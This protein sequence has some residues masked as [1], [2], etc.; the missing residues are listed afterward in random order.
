MTSHTK[1]L[2][3][4]DVC[5]MLCLQTCVGLS[6]GQGG[7]AGP[8]SLGGLPTSLGL[9]PGGFGHS[10]LPFPWHS[11]SIKQTVSSQAQI[12]QPR[13]LNDYRRT[14]TR[15]GGR[16][17]RDVGSRPLSRDLVSDLTGV[18]GRR[19]KRVRRQAPNPG[20]NIRNTPSVERQIVETMIATVGATAPPS[21]DFNR[22]AQRALS[23]IDPNISVPDVHYHAILEQN[24]FPHAQVDTSKAKHS[25]GILQSSHSRSEV[26]AQPRSSQP[27]NQPFSSASVL[28]KTPGQKH[29]RRSNDNTFMRTKFHVAANQGPALFGK[30][31]RRNNVQDKNIRND[32]RLIHSVARQPTHT[33]QNLRLPPSS[34]IQGST[35]TL[36]NRDVSA[37]PSPRNELLLPDT[38]K[39]NFQDPKVTFVQTAHRQTSGPL[40]HQRQTHLS[41]PQMEAQ[42]LNPKDQTHH[43]EPNPHLNKM[44][45]SQPNAQFPGPQETFHASAQINN[46]LS[47]TPLDHQKHM[48]D[49]FLA[50]KISNGI[51]VSENL[52]NPQPMTNQGFTDMQSNQMMSGQ[53]Q[54]VNTPQH[55]NNNLGHNPSI[56]DTTNQQ[57]NLHVSPHSQVFQKSPQVPPVRSDIQPLTSD[58]FPQHQNRHSNQH[59]P[60]AFQNQKSNS[61]QHTSGVFPHQNSNSN[62]HVSS[63]FPQNQNGNSNPQAPSV[64][65]QYQK[66]NL[67]QHTP[68]VFPHQNSNSNQ[69]TPGV[70]Q[71][72]QD[73][74]FNEQPHTTDFF[75]QKAHS[76]QQPQPN[77]DISKHQNEL[78]PVNNVLPVLQQNNNGPNQNKIYHQQPD[79]QFGKQPFTTSKNVRQHHNNGGI[80]LGPQHEFQAAHQQNMDPQS[81]H[82]IRVPNLQTQT[83]HTHKRTNH[84]QFPPHQNPSFHFKEKHQSIRNPESNKLFP[85]QVNNERTGVHKSN[86][87]NQLPLPHIAERQINNPKYNKH[88]SVPVERNYP[89]TQR[90]GTFVEQHNSH[91]S[92]HTNPVFPR[93]N[94]LDLIN[95]Q[96]SKNSHQTPT[97][98]VNGQTRKQGNPETSQSNQQSSQFNE[99][100]NHFG[101]QDHQQNPSSNWQDKFPSPNRPYNPSGQS[102]INTHEVKHHSVHSRKDVPRQQTPLQQIHNEKQPHNNNFHHLE[103][104]KEQGQRSRTETQSRAS[105]FK[106]PGAVLDQIYSLSLDL[107]SAVSSPNVSTQAVNNQTNRRANLNTQ[108]NNPSHTQNPPT[109]AIKTQ[110]ASMFHKLQAVMENLKIIPAN[111]IDKKSF[112]KTHVPTTPSTRGHSQWK[113]TSQRRETLKSLTPLERTKQEALSKMHASLHALGIPVSFDSNHLHDAAPLHTTPSPLYTPFQSKSTVNHTLQQKS[114]PVQAQ[115]E[116][117]LNKVASP[118][119]NARTMPPS[120]RG[121][122]PRTTSSPF[123]P[124]SLWKPAPNALSGQPMHNANARESPQ[125]RPHSNKPHVGEVGPGVLT[126]DQVIQQQHQYRPEESYV[127]QE[128]HNGNMGWLNARGSGRRFAGTMEMNDF[129]ANHLPKTF[130]QEF[131][132]A[133]NPSTPSPPVTSLNSLP[134][135]TQGVWSKNK[136]HPPHSKNWNKLDKNG[137]DFKQMTKNRIQSQ[138]RASTPTTTQS[139]VQVSTLSDLQM[140]NYMNSNFN[141]QKFI[142]FFQKRLDAQN[143]TTV[144]EKK[145]KTTNITKTIRKI[146]KPARPANSSTAHAPTTPISSFS[147]SGLP[148][149]PHFDILP[150]R[151]MSFDMPTQLSPTELPPFSSNSNMNI[152]QATEIIKLLEALQTLKNAL[153]HSNSGGGSNF[154]NIYNKKDQTPTVKIVL[155]V[156]DFDNRY[157][158]V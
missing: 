23:I 40:N 118:I 44:L 18:I 90:Q 4:V 154:G 52:K 48:S 126:R 103:S 8:L 11:G 38:H 30:H 2:F 141:L 100:R 156:S 138:P 143:S 136:Q 73:G 79:N 123:R 120:A 88:N 59:T 92:Q 148:V 124:V 27:S 113:S 26:I 62:Q 34:N 78:S 144:D 31:N 102:P 146:E 153:G 16:Q 49:A 84:E 72:H 111:T 10:M 115:K 109:R 37:Q 147:N 66:S 87:N 47:G 21:A 15:S 42:S 13:A 61:N 158:G 5:M 43:L 119:I 131:L 70:F 83:D 85:S 7:I 152:T 135:T 33:Q 108:M 116:R 149:S 32:R 125:I 64:F 157:K 75:S 121:L 60:S 29:K 35:F 122:P 98:S 132:Q 104:Q 25:A 41:D 155:H 105:N 45:T 57:Q 133:Y 106:E 89:R 54:S 129:K 130:G 91:S 74:N 9:Q 36:V 28:R 58:I 86:N 1:Q 114:S 68:G 69:H 20:T 50:Q 51:V 24:N 110:L 65:P 94:K 46:P 19:H 137:K 139:S 95:G 151:H 117:L 12:Q 55:Q 39:T 63:V 101:R 76:S 96:F 17:G 93:N 71:Q 56:I 134:E 107:V 22:K 82:H 145:I 53:E 3:S 128:Q 140:Q 112:A 77:F 14:Y 127:K 81:K 67:N 97:H 142:K 6:R 80:V 99:R 150:I